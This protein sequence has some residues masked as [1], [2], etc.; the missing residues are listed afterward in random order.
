[1]IDVATAAFL[2]L[3]LLAVAT[4]VWAIRTAGRRRPNP[5]RY[6]SKQTGGHGRFIK[7]SRC[8]RR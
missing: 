2:I 1:L 3:V 8:H 7:P 5:S 6:M 4:I